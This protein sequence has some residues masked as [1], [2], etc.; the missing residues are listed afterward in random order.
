MSV[1]AGDIGGTH[2]RLALF[3]T[4]AGRSPVLTEERTVRSADYPGPASII[5]E[6]LDGRQPS[7]DD[8]L[9]GVCVAIAG[10]IRDGVC[11]VPN[12]GWTIEVDRFG[13]DVG[14][15]S[16]TLINDFEAIGYGVPLLEPK[17]YAELQA[18]AGRARAPIA[19]IGPGTGLGQAFL[20]W[21]GAA[22]RVR[23]SEGGHAD[24]A[25]RTA[26]EWALTGHLGERFGHASWER[27]I[28]GPGLVEIYGF[29]AATEFAAEATS[30]REE[31]ATEDRASVI[32]RHG[33]EGTDELCVKALH[34]F[35]SAF[36]AQAGNLA[37][38]L[39]AYGGVY[40]AGGI[41]PR[42]LKKLE[43]GSFMDAFLG[44]GRLS[45]L[46][47][48]IPVRVILDERIGLRGAARV[49]SGATV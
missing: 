36:G 6:Y 44:K 41:A 3:T 43:D 11:R 8:D 46:L 22:Y 37:L 12:L 31:L 7:I 29:L 14:L 1:L 34:M 30:V 47:A 5:R 20:I 2:A 27:V 13:T 35:V 40:L 19:I 9:E 21:E 15:P 45:G 49:A 38:T 33:M 17:D 25:P 32:S 18:G 26:L 42:I 28:S 23:A 16:A 24:F 4:E 39:A 10:P 48:G